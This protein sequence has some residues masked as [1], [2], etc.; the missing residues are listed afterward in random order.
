M[1]RH[2]GGEGAAG[3]GRNQL[4]SFFPHPNELF[5]KRSG[6]FVVMIKP[7]NLTTLVQ[8]YF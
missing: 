7:S 2:G 6:L 8:P 5:P 1:G 3:G 4:V